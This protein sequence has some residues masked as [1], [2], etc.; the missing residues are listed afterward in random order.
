MLIGHK[1]IRAFIH[2]FIP[3]I[4]LYLLRTSPITC[5]G[6]LRYSN[7]WSYKDDE[8]GSSTQ[9]QR[10]NFDTGKCSLWHHVNS[11]PDDGGPHGVFFEDS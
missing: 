7:P 10:L 3:S 2:S 11:N 9:F 8:I 1:E 5:P 4:N 6:K